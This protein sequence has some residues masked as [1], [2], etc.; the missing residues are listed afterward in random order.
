MNE[1]PLATRRVELERRLDASRDDLALAVR[2]L[3]R[4]SRRC[5]APRELARRHPWAVLTGAGL[6]GLWLGLRSE[7]LLSSPHPR[8]RRTK[9]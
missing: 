9:R 2:E 3:G 7:A 6:L 5:V 4:A 8:P 1:A